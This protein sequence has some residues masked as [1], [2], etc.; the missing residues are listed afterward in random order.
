MNMKAVIPLVLALV[1]GLVAAF[2]AKSA[3]S[4]RSQPQTP[5][6]NLV[7][8]VT[9]RQ[10]VAPGHQLSKEDLVTCNV[11]AETASTQVFSDPAQL[12]GRVTAIALVKGQTVFETLLAPTGTGSGLQALVPAGMRAITLEVTE[13]SGVGG[14]LTPGCHVDVIS[15]VRDEKIHES[16]ARTI[17]Q[18]IKVQAVGRAITNAPP[19]GEKPGQPQGAANNI[20]LLCTPRQAQVI[21]LSTTTGRPWFVL[22]SGQDGRELPVEG[23][24]MAELR[25]DNSLSEVAE[26]EPGTEYTSKPGVP[27]I[28]GPAPTAPV[29]PVIE[30]VAPPAPPAVT[31]RIVQ[32]LR[33]GTESQVTFVVPN[34][35]TATADLPLAPETH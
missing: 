16:V 34:P 11:P 25:G 7:A 19:E 33:G 9:A 22:R 35:R 17:L 8:V 31:K 6:G 20:T 29:A 26:N 14:M 12:V 5:Q 23:T 18:N 32:I 21:Q 13:F 27:D 1:L 2:L 28:F 30:T 10:G 3:V 4:R 15:V 24:T